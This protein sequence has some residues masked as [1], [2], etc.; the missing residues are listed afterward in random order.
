MHVLVI[1][2][3]SNISCFDLTF[4]KVGHTGQYIQCKLHYNLFM[5]VQTAAKNP[6]PWD[7]RA[8]DFLFK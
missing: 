6:V 4:R 2:H 1:N 5:S 8:G 3:V 7:L